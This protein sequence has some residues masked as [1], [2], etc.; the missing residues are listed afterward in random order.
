[1]LKKYSLNF[2]ANIFNTITTMR[3][4]LFI[5]SIFIL[6]SCQQEDTPTPPP[7]PDREDILLTR[8][9]QEMVS[10]GNEFAFSLFRE[11]SRNDNKDNVLISPL[12]AGM[13]LAM[14]NNGAAGNTMEQI[15]ST[16]GF[17]DYSLKEM[18]NYYNKMSKGL[19]LVDTSTD[20]NLANSIWIDEEFPIKEPFAKIN[21]ETYDSEIHNI[22]FGSPVTL[23]VINKWCAD[24]T[25]NKIPNLLDQLSSS[26]KLL[27]INALYFKGT[28]KDKFE[29]KNTSKKEFTNIDGSKATVDMMQNK[30]DLL[31]GYDNTF[32]FVELPYGNEA[33]S[34]VILLPEK[35]KN[36]NSLIENFEINHWNEIKKRLLKTEVD[37]E[38]PRFKIEYGKYFNDELINMGMESAFTPAA[39]FSNISDVPLHVAFVLQKTVIEVNEE[40]TEAAASTAIGMEMYDPGPIQK[41][42]AVKFHVDRPFIYM[43]KEKSTGAILFV[44]KVASL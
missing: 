11:V 36:I 8:S 37:L 31:Y 23:N 29:K 4:Y 42:E 41:P 30:K 9:E 26:T 43:I 19:F 3:K 2:N 27:L 14:L 44:G 17:N 35:N 6:F 24:K 12:S 16:L 40:G 1:M 15:K 34:M 32:R 18:N 10:K 20:F 38:L 39:N 5:L 28:W 25:K 7:L 22:D 13:A 21:R 33:F